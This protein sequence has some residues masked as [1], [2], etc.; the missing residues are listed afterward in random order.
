LERAVL[1]AISIEIR[2]RGASDLQD[3]SGQQIARLLEEWCSTD[4]EHPDPQDLQNALHM[5][6]MTK[7]LTP[8]GSGSEMRYHI[9]YPAYIDFMSRLE[10]LQRVEIFKSLKDYHKEE[11]GQ[12]K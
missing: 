2:S 10:K 12:I 8:I 7:M 6:S 11:K 5:L 9:T 3:Y 1:L 4:I